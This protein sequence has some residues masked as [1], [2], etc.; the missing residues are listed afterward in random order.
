MSRKRLLV[1]GVVSSYGAL[2]AQ[3]FYSL[4]SIPLVLAYTKQAEFGM[5]GLITTLMGY[6][7]LFEMGMTNAVIRHLFECRDSKEDG[8]YGRLFV[9][10]AMALGVA[11][12][13]MLVVGIGASFILA[14]VFHI[15]PE[16]KGTF[17]FLMI[18]NV[19]IAAISMATRILGTPLYVHQRQDLLQASQIF[20]FI[21]LFSILFLG[22]RAGWGIYAM[23]ANV[24]AGMIWSLVFSVIACRR[25]RLYPPAGT[26]AKPLRSEWKSI[27]TF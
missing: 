5:W 12:A 20:L 14:P 21:L 13:L 4:A 19:V 2:A 10:G 1:R 15:P 27:L 16:L 26:W 22:L 3:I 24:T 7:G 18:G 23:L 17:F 25:L 9:A 8:R 6:L 11:G